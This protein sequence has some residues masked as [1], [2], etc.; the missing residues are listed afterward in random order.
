MLTAQRRSRR[1]APL[2]ELNEFLIRCVAIASR[3]V[4]LKPWLPRNTP[5]SGVFLKMLRRDPPSREPLKPDTTDVF[6]YAL[7]DL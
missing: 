5:K 6:R 1:P 4:R 2:E 7:S 3:K